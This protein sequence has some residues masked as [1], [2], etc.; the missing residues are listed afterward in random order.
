MLFGFGF[1]VV[2]NIEFLLDK[3]TFKQIHRII[4][5]MLDTF[6]LK[7]LEHEFGRD[8]QYIFVSFLRSDN[9]L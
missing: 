9:I 1:E 6:L 7:F 4:L 5:T 2:K 3:S 8:E